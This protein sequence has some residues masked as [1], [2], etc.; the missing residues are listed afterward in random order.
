MIGIGRL[1]WMRARSTAFFQHE[2][3]LLIYASGTDADG[4]PTE[5][6]TAGESFACDLQERSS[7][8]IEA[9]QGGRIISRSRWIAYAGITAPGTAKDRLEINGAEYEIVEST[10]ARQ[11][12]VI[13][14]HL[15]RLGEG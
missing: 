8:A 14:F 10:R 5:T 13:V 2:A 15:L 4:N 3:Q 12:A 7:E 11:G 6:W 1:G 9:A